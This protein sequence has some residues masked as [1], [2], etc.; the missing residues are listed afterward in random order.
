V[1]QYIITTLGRLKNT[2]QFANIISLKPLGN[3][4]GIELLIYGQV[5]PPRRPVRAA[6]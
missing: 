2:D 5:R 4:F 1:T 6:V 3:V